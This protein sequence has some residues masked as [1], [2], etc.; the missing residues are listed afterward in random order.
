MTSTTNRKRKQQQARPQ[1]LSRAQRA[2]VDDIRAGGILRRR[3]RG[4]DQNYWLGETR[5]YVQSPRAVAD[6]LVRHGLARWAAC[7][8]PQRE[9]ATHWLVLVSL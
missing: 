1:V 3:G 4:P 2:L 9:R 5:A 7:E 8:D 6:A